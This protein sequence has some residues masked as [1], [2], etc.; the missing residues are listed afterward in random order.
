MRT[1]LLAA[2]AL[3]V[4]VLGIFFWFATMVIARNAMAQ[5]Q[6]AAAEAAARAQAE[7]LAERARVEAQRAK[8]IAQEAAAREAEAKQAAAAA[9][10]FLQND[11]SLEANNAGSKRKL[12]ERMEVALDQQP[13]SELL[14]YLDERLDVEFHAQR[15][16]IEAAGL[17]LDAPVSL[18]FKRIRGDMLLDL[19]LRQVSPDLGYVIRDG[20]VIVTTRDAVA[21]NQAVRVYNCRELL[22]A[23]NATPVAPQPGGNVPPGPGPGAPVGG[24][25]PGMA[26]SLGSGMGGG[27]FGQPPQ[28]PAQ[29]LQQVIRTTIAPETWD[30]VGGP[31]TMEEFGGLL[32][33]NQ[34][35]AVHDRIEKLL[36]MLHEAA[37]K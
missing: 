28:T 19:A 2:G 21:G 17:S 8:L 7:A 18:K 11:D 24:S 13:L 12:A 26:G 34:S 22:A 23:V 30:T 4:V 9:V 29:Q 36:Q 6:R 32:V 10:K 31:G 25:P 14:A 35:E 27:F 1:R 16:D 5:D 20:I 15:G 37:A 33:V 3:S